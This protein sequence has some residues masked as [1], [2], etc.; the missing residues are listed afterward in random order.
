MKES[1]SDGTAR[2]YWS[3]MQKFPW[4]SLKNEAQLKISGMLNKKVSNSGDITAV[5]QFLNFLHEE[6]LKNEVP[7][8]EF[9]ELRQKKDMIQ[10]AIKLPESKK[11]QSS[12]KEQI[13]KKHI[14]SW[15]LVK[16]LR[17][18]DPERAKFWF[19]L[20]SGGFRIGELKRM[21][22]DNLFDN[23]EYEYG[24]IHVPNIK[25]RSREDRTWR[26]RNPYTKYIL[27]HAPTGEWTDE[28]GNTHE[29]VFFPEFT[30]QN[31]RWHL[32]KYTSRD[33][34][35][36]DRSIRIGRKTPHC[37]RHSRITHLVWD[38]KVE[39]SMEKIQQ[40]VGHK[41]SKTT[42]RYIETSFERDPITLETYAERKDL[43]IL[44]EVINQKVE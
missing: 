4:F 28:N 15:N 40:R 6:W 19:A 17:K 22:T 33:D 14:H 35:F 5:N 44:E 30:A 11:N 39:M 43:D 27:E 23:D 7:D 18:A 29:D 9:E 2:T 32:K 20:Y 26:F 8:R 3:K 16:M 21:S 24:G 37:F 34:N 31:Q 1:K 36:R 42:Q 10:A 12:K 41:D 13:K 25:S 38:D